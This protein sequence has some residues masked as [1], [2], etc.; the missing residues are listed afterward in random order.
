M[1]KTR[2]QALAAIAKDRISQLGLDQLAQDKMGDV[3][4][5]L[6][7]LVDERV[8]VVAKPA[9]TEPTEVA[10]RPASTEPSTTTQPTFY[11]EEDLARMTTPE[12]IRKSLESNQH[13]PPEIKQRMLQELPAEFPEKYRRLVGAYYRE[14][15]DNK[16]EGSG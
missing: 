10:V 16:Q 3:L 14:L 5:R 12:A 7:D 8:A 4:D 11:T 1:Q 9:T 15:L 13:L 2:R 6:K